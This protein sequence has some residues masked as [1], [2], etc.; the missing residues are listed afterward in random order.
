M[1]LLLV[2]VSEVFSISFFLIFFSDDSLNVS[3][4]GPDGEFVD[5]SI[6]EARLVGLWTAD[7]EAD[8]RSRFALANET[9]ASLLLSPVRPVSNVLQ[10][11]MVSFIICDWF[12]LPIFPRP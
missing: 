7:V 8:W 10:S 5:L 9:L 3:L 11:E 2:C 4:L 1:C 12:L 6:G